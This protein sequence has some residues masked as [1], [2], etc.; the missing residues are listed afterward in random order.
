[1]FLR[2]T[3]TD[4]PKTETLVLHQYNAV[5]LPSCEGFNFPWTENLV[6]AINL[7]PKNK[8]RWL[9]DLIKLFPYFSDKKEIGTKH[10]W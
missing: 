8:S 4:Y 2:K 10:Y 9:T 3:V 6:A 5:Q 1:M 7:V